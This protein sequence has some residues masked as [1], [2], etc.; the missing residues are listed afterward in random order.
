MS[1]VIIQ[2]IVYNL[3]HK[4]IEKAHHQDVMQGIYDGFNGSLNSEHICVSL[5]SQVYIIIIIIFHSHINYLA[6]IKLF[7]SLRTCVMNE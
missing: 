1:K 2:K 4:V 6:Q 3:S 7:K 5:R